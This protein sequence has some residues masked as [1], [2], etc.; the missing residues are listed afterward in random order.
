MKVCIS[1]NK[2]SDTSVM[3]ITCL[4]RSVFEFHFREG[5]TI[6]LMEQ[7]NFLTQL[8]TSVKYAPHYS[9]EHM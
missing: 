9:I 4:I 5:F 6:S 1:T 8:K 3:I 2:V 7:L